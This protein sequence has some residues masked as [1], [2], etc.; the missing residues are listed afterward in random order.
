VT[1]LVTRRVLRIV[2]ATAAL[3]CLWH[4]SLAAQPASRPV[5]IGGK[6]SDEGCAGTATVVVSEGSTLN[7]RTGPAT[8]YPVAVRLS[9]GQSVS[10]CQYSG[11]GWVGVVVHQRVRGTDCRLSD[12]GPKARPY[13]GPCESGWVKEQ[14]LRL[15][16]G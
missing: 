15:F 12:A 5:L 9:P 10:I 14:F 16:A 6:E 7:L 8:T 11:N 13:A 1:V 3:L 2:C 4:G